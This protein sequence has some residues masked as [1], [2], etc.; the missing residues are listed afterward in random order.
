MHDAQPAKIAAIEI[1]ML[2]FV[3]SGL[4]GRREWRRVVVFVE[5]ISG[6]RDPRS[7]AARSG[8]AGV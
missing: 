2:L 1:L 3:K 4:F 7:S 6:A 5:R 8:S